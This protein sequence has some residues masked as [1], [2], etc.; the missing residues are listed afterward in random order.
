MLVVFSI[1]GVLVIRKMASVGGTKIYRVV[2]QI[3]LHLTNVRFASQVPYLVQWSVVLF[4]FLL[5]QWGQYPSARPTSTQNNLLNLYDK[6]ISVKPL[7]ILNTNQFFV[8]ASLFFKVSLVLLAPPSTKITWDLSTLP[9][10]PIRGYMTME[11]RCL[12]GQQTCLSWNPKGIYVVLSRG[13]W[14]TQDIQ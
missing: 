10:E 1:L 14:E 6:V 13:R 11:L 8:A 9:K 2:W 5:L 12:T 7:A 3:N 4:T